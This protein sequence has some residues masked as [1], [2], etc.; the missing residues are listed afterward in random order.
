[1]STF[2]FVAELLARALQSRRIAFEPITKLAGPI[3]VIGI[4]KGNMIGVRKGN[5]GG[6]G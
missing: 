3:L 6:V 4:G 1:M 5:T 2:A